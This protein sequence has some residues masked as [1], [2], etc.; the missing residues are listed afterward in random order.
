MV[1][2]YGRWTEEQDYN[3]YPKEKWCD[4]DYVADYIRKQG[5]EPKIKIDIFIE[6][7]V[8]HFNSETE[9]NS[10][11]RP[12]YRKDNFMIN[13]PK[14]ASFVEASGGLKEFDYEY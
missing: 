13:I 5:Y 8:D 11:F 9:N 12:A 14:L 2:H 10:M 1:D 4:M 6:T 7:I 3:T